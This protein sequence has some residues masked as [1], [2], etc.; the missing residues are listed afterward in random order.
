M[1]WGAEIAQAAG[2]TQYGL[3]TVDGTAVA[4][5]VIDTHLRMNPSH[6]CVSLDVKGARSSIYRDVLEEICAARAPRMGQF[7][8][9]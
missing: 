5:S 9:R 6:L 1:C 3:N 7:L 4:F 2:P 8:R